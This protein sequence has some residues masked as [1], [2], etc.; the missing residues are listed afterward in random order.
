MR[1]SVLQDLIRSV[2]ETSGCAR[3][4]ARAK[5]K[6]WLIS[7]VASMNQRDIQV[8][9]SHFAYLLPAEWGVAS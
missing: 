3:T 4:D 8:A 7:H 5:A 6:A 9:R 1:S 2:E